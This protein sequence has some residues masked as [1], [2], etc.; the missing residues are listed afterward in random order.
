MAI[1]DKEIQDAL[2]A[3]QR[4]L[5]NGTAG[6]LISEIHTLSALLERVMKERPL[7]VVDDKAS[8]WLLF[9]AGLIDREKSILAKVEREIRRPTGLFSNY[10]GH[11]LGF[12]IDELSRGPDRPNWASITARANEI[13]TALRSHFGGIT[14]EK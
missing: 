6:L 8:A 9:K 10:E 13:T 4:V 2:D 14:I 1:T 3:S 5:R 11:L 12:V 7:P